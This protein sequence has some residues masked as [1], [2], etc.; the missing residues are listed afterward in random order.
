M[1]QDFKMKANVHTF[2][3][4]ETFTTYDYEFLH[5]NCI[6]ISIPRWFKTGYYYIEELG[7]FRYISK[8]DESL[9]NGKEYDENINWNDTI[10]LYDKNDNLIYDPS[11][12]VDKRSSMENENMSKNKSEQSDKGSNKDIIESKSNSTTDNGDTGA[13]NYDDFGEETIINDENMTE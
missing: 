13:E 3:S 9:Y 1:Y 12:G 5:S 10:I 4:L 2:G 11:T 8:S 6:E 7:M